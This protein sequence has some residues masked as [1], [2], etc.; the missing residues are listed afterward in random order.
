MTKLKD[1]RN[2]FAVELYSFRRELEVDFGGT[3]RELRK[4]GWQAVQIDGL[5]GNSA[6]HIA[7]VLKETEM[8]VAGMHVSL[9]RM[10]NDTDKVIYEGL[11]FGTKDIFC[12]SLPEELQNEEGYRYVK[13][14]LLDLAMRLNSLGFRVGYHN[15]E[16]E[17]LSKVDNRTAYNYLMMPEGNC[18]I[19]PEVDTYWVQYAEI[20]PLSV[21]KR[22][23]E[24]MP[25]LHLKDIKSDKRLTYPESLAEIGTGIIDFVPILQW[26]EANGT[27]W[28]VV[29]Q[30]RSFL[31]G[32]MMESYQISFN[33]LLELQEQL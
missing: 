26:G 1:I 22:F 6:E 32:G 30:D 14:S 15:H 9:D 18:F 2:K 20:D 23:P 31:D 21:I 25:I 10:L 33:N 16:F 24:K 19:Y 27:E 13:S 11:L 3:I 4:M 12:N 17:F 29:E 7:A 28:Y 8:R 5:R